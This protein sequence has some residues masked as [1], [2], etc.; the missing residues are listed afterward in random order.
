MKYS[1]GTLPNWFVKA[2]APH[3]VGP[4]AGGVQLPAALPVEV[5][6]RNVKEF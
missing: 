1:P 4:H 2:A 3:S 5:Y 6:R